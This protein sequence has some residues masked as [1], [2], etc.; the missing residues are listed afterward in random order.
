MKASI[1]QKD[2][3]REVMIKV[4]IPDPKLWTTDLKAIATLRP[5]LPKHSQKRVS[6]QPQHSKEPQY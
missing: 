4:L 1:C 6:Q 3:G 2:H 5:S